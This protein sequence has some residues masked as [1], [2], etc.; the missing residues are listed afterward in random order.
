MT[1]HH[2]ED[3]KENLLPRRKRAIDPE[4][5]NVD[6]M[7]YDDDAGL[8]IDSLWTDRSQSSPSSTGTGNLG[9]QCEIDRWK[10]RI[11]RRILEGRK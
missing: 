9:N 8:T 11:F 7:A 6:S 5:F 3:I 10:H 4:S 1:H 2:H